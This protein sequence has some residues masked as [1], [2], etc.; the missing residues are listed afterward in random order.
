M[1][2]MNIDILSTGTRK[3]ML[4]IPGVAFL[5]IKKELAEQLK[6]RHTGWFGQENKTKF[7]IFNSTYAPGARCFETG[8]PS[9][10]SVYAAYEALNLLLGVGINHIHSYLKKLAAFTREFGLQSGLQIS[11]P[12]ANEGTSGLTSFYMDNASEIEKRLREKNILVSA[13]KDVIRI[14]PHFYNKKDEVEYAVTELS[15]FAK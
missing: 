2:E 9:F 3:Y 13:R 8:T 14:A 6:P 1:K 12:L 4:G 5:Y 15:K 7:D 10:I 11:S